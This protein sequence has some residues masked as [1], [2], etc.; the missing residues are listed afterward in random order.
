[1]NN[2]NIALDI[3]SGAVHV[4]DD[5]AFDVLGLYKSSTREEIFNSLAYSQNEIVEAINELKGLESAGTLFSEDAY[6]GLLDEIN[7]REPVV[8]AICLHVTHDC[9]LTCKYC[10]ADEGGYKGSRSLMSFETGKAALDFLIRNSGGRRN[11]EVDFFGGEP[12][13]NFDVVKKL[14]EYARAEEKK[15]NKNFRFTVTTNGLLLTEEIQSYINENMHNVVLSIDGRK[16]INDNMRKT[17]TGGGSYDIIMPKFKKLA[18]SR[19]QTNYY[20]RGT[21]T[22]GNLDFSGDVLHLADEGFKQI[23]VEPVVADASEAYAIQVQ[24]LDMV[25]KEYEALA[26][27]IISRKKNNQDFNFFHFMLDLEGGPCVSKRI[28]GCG[29]GTEYLAVAPNGGL[30]PCHQFVGNEEFKIGDIYSGIKNHSLTEEFEK[31][32]VYTKEACKECF[33]KFYC[34]GGCLSNAYNFNKSIQKPYEIGC[35]M[36]RKRVECAIMLKAHEAFASL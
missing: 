25:F 5:V 34:S 21:F 23:S 6:A 1:M 32:N 13:M 26:L 11:L 31:C 33:A 14:V 18:D 30:Y 2:Y 10:F 16:E 12:L 7:G 8:K 27:K 19:G 15:H 29:A 35:Q 24:D 20:V 28:A 22:K 36:Q 9:N 3:N 4:L 17:K